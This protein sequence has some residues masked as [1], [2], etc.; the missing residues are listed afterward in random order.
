MRA[1]YVGLPIGVPSLEL[2][3]ITLKDTGSN[4]AV[5]LISL[6]TKFKGILMYRNDRNLE[7]LLFPHFTSISVY[8]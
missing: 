4:V 2:N 6:N 8:I 3:I 1:T 5:R 7:R